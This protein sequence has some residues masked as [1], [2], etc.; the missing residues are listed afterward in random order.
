MVGAIPAAVL[1]PT[2]I[3]IAIEVPA[4]VITPAQVYVPAKHYGRVVPR[5]LIS[6]IASG[7]NSLL[8]GLPSYVASGMLDHFARESLTFC[9]C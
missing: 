3:P 9:Q 2:P 6:D 4:P 7:V 8:D 1:E 5:N